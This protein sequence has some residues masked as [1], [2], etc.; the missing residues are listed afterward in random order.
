MIYQNHNID[1]TYFYDAIDEF[2]FDYKIYVVN[3]DEELDDYGRKKNTY[4]QQIINGS[5]QSQ[6]LT[7]KQSKSGNTHDKSYK[8]YCKSLYK[9][10]IGDIIE[11]KGEYFRTNFV[12]DYDEYGVREATLKM[13]TLTQYRDFADYIKYLSGEKLV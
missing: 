7:E 6:G 2:A 10:N 12:Q 1:P 5:L 8:F 11:Y 9:I 13:I 3:E 4:T